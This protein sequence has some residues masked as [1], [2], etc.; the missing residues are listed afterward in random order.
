LGDRETVLLDERD[1]TTIHDNIYAE[2][3]YSRIEPVPFQQVV[4]EGVQ[5]H[6]YTFSVI[7]TWHEPYGL[8]GW[9]NNGSP[10]HEITLIAA[11]VPAVL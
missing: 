11:M 6:W 3:A 8:T 7:L 5:D 1:P 9:E 4:A 10:P 2:L